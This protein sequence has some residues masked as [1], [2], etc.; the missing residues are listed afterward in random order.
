MAYATHNK[1]RVASP[2]YPRPLVSYRKPLEKKATFFFRE[3]R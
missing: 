2:I 1:T 3:K